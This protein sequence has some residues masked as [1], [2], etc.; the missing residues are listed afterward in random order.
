MSNSCRICSL[1]LYCVRE[2]S[3][4]EMQAAQQWVLAGSVDIHCQLS[5][6]KLLLFVFIGPGLNWVKART[7]WNVALSTNNIK[8]KAS[9]FINQ[10]LN[11]S[12]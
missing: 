3:K 11:Q 12:N 10:W 7:L 5:P 1:G 8:I 4:V 9:C 6:T 2:A